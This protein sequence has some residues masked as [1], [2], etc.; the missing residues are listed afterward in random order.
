MRDC[1]VFDGYF[2]SAAAAEC[3]PGEGPHSRRATWVTAV[4]RVPNRLNLVVMLCE[5]VAGTVF[6]RAGR[7][8]H[9]EPGQP[10][11]WPHSDGSADR[12]VHDFVTAA[13]NAFA[14]T[15]ARSDS[16]ASVEIVLARAAA[17][18]LQ[19]E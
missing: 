16:D 19:N 17:D 4:D 15:D 3:R 9:R 11:S 1:E 6:D 14:A 18:D 10:N 12:D 2:D 5:I 8:V 13:L 7:S